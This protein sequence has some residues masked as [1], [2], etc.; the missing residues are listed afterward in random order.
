MS[1]RRRFG[2]VRQLASGRWQAR[3]RDP[4]TNQHRTAEHT[5]PTKTA[6]SKWLSA[7]ETDIARGVW[8]DPRRGEVSFAEV[9]EQ[10]FA[11]K[12]HLRPSTQHLYRMLLDRH[13]LPTFAEIRVGGITTLDVQMWISDRHRNTRMGANSVAKTYK[14][15]RA[16]MESALDAGLIGWRPVLGVNRRRA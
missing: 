15:L 2:A 10:W 3:F 16:V 5:F 14:V 12:L 1:G 6:A 8:H 9:A 4:E 11:T 13:I 7:L